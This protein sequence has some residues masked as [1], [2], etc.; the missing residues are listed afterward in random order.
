M[1]MGCEIVKN[2][3]L[4]P[5]YG[6]ALIQ[7]PSLFNMQCLR[8]PL[9]RSLQLLNYCKFC[10]SVKDVIS[11]IEMLANWYRCGFVGVFSLVVYSKIYLYL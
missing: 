7:G 3:L 11:V 4:G 1:E 2:L 8:V 6:G 10:I 5:K 9:S